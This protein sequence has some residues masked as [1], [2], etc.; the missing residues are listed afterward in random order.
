[1]R[2]R[3]KTNEQTKLCWHRCWQAVLSALL[4]C[5]PEGKHFNKNMQQ[6][7]NE[8]L[9]KSPQELGRFLISTVLGY[10]V[11]FG[12]VILKVPQILKILRSGSADGVSLTANLIELTGYAISTSWAVAQKFEFKDFGENVF[13]LAQLVVLIGLVSFHQRSLGFGIAGIIGILSAMYAL[14]IGAVSTSVHKSLLSFQLVLLLSSRVPQIYMSYR[15]RST[16]QLAFLTFFL[17]FG[18]GCARLLTVFLNVPWENGKGTLLVQFGAAV[19][20]NGIILSQIFLY[21]NKSA[22][23]KTPAAVTAKKTDAVS[24]KK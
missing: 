12:S 24:K 4:K 20:L 19:L 8:L 5:L 9:Q 7:I 11:V 22:T 10:G 18:G 13:I 14:C 21:G 23:K 15:N 17:A 1:M 2:F 3:L 16:G 6:Q